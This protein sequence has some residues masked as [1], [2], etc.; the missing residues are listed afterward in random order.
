[1]NFETFTSFAGLD[2]KPHQAEAVEWCLKNETTG[3]YVGGN[4]IRG[5]LIADEMGLGK[6]I[7]ILGTI[8]ANFKPRTLIVVPRALLEQWNHIIRSIMK[9]EPLIFHGIKKKE[10][11]LEDVKARSIVLTTYGMISAL[12]GDIPEQPKYQT[13]HKIKWDRVI[14]DEAHHLRNKNTQVHLGALGLKSN[15]R[16]LMTGTP[17]QNSKDDFYALCAVMGLPNDYYVRTGNLIDLV[18]RFILKRTKS[19]VGIILPALESNI[20]N[21]Q[22]D[23]EQEKMLAQDIH[24]RVRTCGISKEFIPCVVLELLGDSTLAAMIRARQMCVYP[25]LLKKSVGELLEDGVI[26][27]NDPIF[28]AIESRSKIDTVINT[29]LENKNNGN[30]KLVFCHYKGEIDTLARDLSRNGMIVEKFDGRIT[31]SMRNLILRRKDLDV[32]I[33]QIKTGCEGLN[34]QHFNEIYFVSPHWNPALQ[35]QAVARCHRIGQTQPVKI[36]RFIMNSFDDQE[37]TCTLDKYSTN[38]QEQKRNTMDMFKLEN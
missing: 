20:I 31:N 22:W 4:V 12:K 29:I 16:W 37:K 21:V 2:C 34:L 36:Y 5:G 14:F 27:H 17:I 38:V 9:H 25:A 26:D 1:M 19:D 13:L 3:H 30:S 18:Q 28:Q 8:V 33:L 15:I 6:T 7:E 10:L 11:E 24:S 32:L 35:D 23:S